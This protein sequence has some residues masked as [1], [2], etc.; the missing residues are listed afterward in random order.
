MP[1]IAAAC[2]SGINAG[3][4]RSLLFGV[5]VASLISA[6]AMY[7]WGDPDHIEP[8][9]RFMTA[10][11]SSSHRRWDSYICLTIF[12]MSALLSYPFDAITRLSSPSLIRNRDLRLMAL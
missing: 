10:G 11:A 5:G 8:R 9:Q 4:A 1:Q 7:S 3:S 12:M 6:M 2:V